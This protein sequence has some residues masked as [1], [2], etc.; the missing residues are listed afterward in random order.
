MFGQTTESR[1]LWASIKGKIGAMQRLPGDIE[2][3]KG[4]IIVMMRQP[5]V[6]RLDTMHPTRVQ[7][8]KSLAKLIGMK[9]EANT[10]ATKIARYLPDWRSAAGETTGLGLIPIIL[11]VASAGALAF[12]AVKGLEL[13]KT[14][15]Q[16]SGIIDSLKSKTLTLEEARELIKVSK[17]GP[18]IEAGFGFG[19]GMTL[20]PIALG[21][22]AL[23][24]F[25]GKPKGAM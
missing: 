13:L 23:F 25:F 11:G 10:V 2:W 3:R 14:Y 12:V 9:S 22:L 19:V 6:T 20:V 1:G 21:G 17:P 15:K 16:E 7:L 18:M 5:S 24:W 8:R 4:E